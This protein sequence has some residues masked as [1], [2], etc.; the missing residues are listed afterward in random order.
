M[1]KLVQGVGINDAGYNINIRE[2]ISKKGEKQKQRT[3]WACPFY[4]RWVNILTRCYSP[5]EHKRYPQ[6]IGCSI[7]DEWKL[8]STFRKWMV[9]KEW[10]GKHLDK[11]LLICG[12]KIY[13]PDTCVFIPEKINAFLRTNI[14]KVSKY[15]LGVHLDKKRD[16]FVANCKNPFREK[17]I[18]EYLG[19]FDCP[20]K[21]HIAWK[22]K[23]YEH[24]L[25]L[26]DS[27]NDIRAS[28]ALRIR[29]EY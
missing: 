14:N 19:T 27:L 7:C 3:I 22:T 29:Y 17:N 26:S 18:T 23:K 9:S 8:F 28:N 20:D 25:R 5:S 24:A 2:T 15:P 21:A 13:G 11:D 1:R 10:A 12:N 4:A 16:K 6:Y